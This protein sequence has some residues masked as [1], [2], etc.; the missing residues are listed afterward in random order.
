MK[1]LVVAEDGLPYNGTQLQEGVHNSQNL[2]VDAYRLWMVEGANYHLRPRSQ[3]GLSD[4]S[5]LTIPEKIDSHTKKFGLLF[6]QNKSS[7]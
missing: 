7:F 5:R 2:D 4:E 6:E 1:K 3:E